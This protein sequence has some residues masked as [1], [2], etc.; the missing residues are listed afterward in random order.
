MRRSAVEDCLRILNH[1]GTDPSKGEAID[2]GGAPRVHLDTGFAP[3]PLLSLNPGTVCLDQGFAS[4]L[5]GAPAQ[6]SVDFLDGNAIAHLRERFD[7]VYCF[8]TLEHSAN[9][10]AFCEHLLAITRPGG[11]IYVSTVF[12]WA[13]HPSPEDHFRFSPSGLRLTLESPLNH[14]RETFRVLWAG[15]ESDP[16]GVAL[17]G[18]KAGGRDLAIPP[19]FTSPRELSPSHFNVLAGLE[20]SGFWKRASRLRQGAP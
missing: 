10:F 11:C 1:F 14:L 6:E 9:P 15:W 3:N 4:G 19:P 20:R 7:R 8:D 12:S 13:Y 16:H 5:A 18:Q 17:F 2:V